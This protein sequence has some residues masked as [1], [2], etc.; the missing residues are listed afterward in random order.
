M[1]EQIR[2]SYHATCEEKLGF[3]KRTYT[4]W[5]SQN[6]IAKIEKR[7]T[8]KSR[9][10]LNQEKDTQTDIPEGLQGA[11]EGRRSTRKEKRS[12][13]DQI[14]SRAHEAV[15]KNDTRTLYEITRKLTKWRSNSDKQVRGLGGGTLIQDWKGSTPW[16]QSGTTGPFSLRPSW[17]Y[18]TPMW[19][20]FCNTVL[21]HGSTPKHQT[22]NSKFLWTPAYD[23]S[24]VLDGLPLFPMKNSGEE[25]NRD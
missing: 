4:S 6:T 2:T 14:A 22:R 10:P 24:S 17:S 15:T 23:K 9:M 19:S 18:S 1:L 3:R 13:I 16:S 11:T 20:L 8:I 25:R 21:R 12:N 7:R 5:L